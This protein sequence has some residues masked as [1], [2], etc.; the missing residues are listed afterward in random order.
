MF[1]SD[2]NLTENKVFCSLSFIFSE[3][4]IKF[5]YSFLHFTRMKSLEIC[6][7][8]LC[9]LVV[10]VSTK[11]N[12]I[13]ETYFFPKNYKL[14]RISFYFLWNFSASW[15]SITN[16]SHWV[17]LRQGPNTLYSCFCKWNYV[18]SYCVWRCNASGTEICGLTDIFSHFSFH[19]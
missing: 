15:S 19:L 10:L 14:Y 2:T 9:S 6:K 8:S 11:L 4:Q 1:H 12:V 16:T 17:W 5:F 18:C 3:F 13:Y 7:L